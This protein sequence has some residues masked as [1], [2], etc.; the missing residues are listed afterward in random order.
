MRILHVTQSVNPV[1]GGPIEAIKLLSDAHRRLGHSV[2]IVS[3]DPPEAPW[4]AEFASTV[5]ALGLRVSSYGYTPRLIPWLREHRRD[6]DIVVSH[7]LWQFNGFGTWRAL[8]NSNTPFCV[9]PHGMLDP[10]FKR[11]YPFKH[12]KKWLYWLGAEHR[13]L[14]DAAGV[15]FT[16]EEERSQARRSFWPYRCHELVVSLG[17]ASPAR[18]AGAA[19][20]AVP[21]NIPEASEPAPAAF[22]WAHA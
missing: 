9:F 2:E 3:L 18:R 17:T 7:G 16:C 12:C 19:A 8:H 10:W 14:R 21:R 20:R 1:A 5:Q 15:L 6:F 22:P 13:V 4:V 11:H